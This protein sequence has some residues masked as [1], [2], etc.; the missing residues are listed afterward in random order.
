VYGFQL[1]DL[2]ERKCEPCVNFTACKLQD[3]Y[4]EMSKDF[5]VDVKS[6]EKLKNCL[7]FKKCD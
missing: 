4:K 5:N 7:F 6:Y 2:V 3:A 1:K